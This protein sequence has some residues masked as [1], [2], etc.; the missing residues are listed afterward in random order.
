M[1]KLIASVALV[2]AESNGGDEGDGGDQL[3]HGIPVSGVDLI[4]HHSARQM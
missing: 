2:T 4:S 1:R 3:A